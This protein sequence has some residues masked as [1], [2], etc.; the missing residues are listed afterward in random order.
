MQYL[1]FMYQRGCLYRLKALGERRDMD[2]T[3]EGF[4][5]WMWKGL[6]FLLPFL[7]VGYVFEFYNAYTLYDLSS[8]PEATWQV[9]TPFRVLTA[10]FRQ[11]LGLVPD[12]AVHVVAAEDSQF[13]TEN[14]LHRWR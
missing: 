2:I 5:S 8:H 13:S 1:Q 4:H 6:T 3:I 11:R 14:I 12:V 7:Y 10:M 9:S